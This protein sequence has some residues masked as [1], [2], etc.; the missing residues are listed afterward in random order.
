MQ[1]VNFVNKLYVLSLKI[2][3]KGHEPQLL[4]FEYN[5]DFVTLVYNHMN[6]MNQ[7]CPTP[8]DCICFNA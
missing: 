3:F 8:F 2:I 4:Y 7:L 6:H 5:F 1:V